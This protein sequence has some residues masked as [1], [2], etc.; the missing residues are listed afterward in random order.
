VDNKS[1]LA[2]RVVQTMNRLNVVN[3]ALLQAEPD[4]A[5]GRAM[6]TFAEFVL[7]ACY[8]PRSDLLLGNLLMKLSC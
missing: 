2:E 3:D 1:A 5:V 7:R 6:L 4:G 8:L